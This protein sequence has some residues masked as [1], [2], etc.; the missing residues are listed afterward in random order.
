MVQYAQIAWDNLVLKY[1]T[2]RD[3][4]A[5]TMVSDYYHRAL[6]ISQ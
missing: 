4:N 3:V 5:L 6:H 2:G 1:C